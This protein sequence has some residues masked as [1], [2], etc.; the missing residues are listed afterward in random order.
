MEYHIYGCCLY[1]RLYPICVHCSRVSQSTRSRKGPPM[2][3]TI[4][5]D[6]AHF[7]RPAFWDSAEHAAA[8]TD[9]TPSRKLRCSADD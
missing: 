2:R 6:P 3:R 8:L 1:L 7:E 5:S 4:N 9:G